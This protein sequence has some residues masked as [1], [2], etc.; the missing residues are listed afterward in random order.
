MGQ[1]VGRAVR[2]TDWAFPIVPPSYDASHRL[3]VQMPTDSDGVTVPAL[4]LAPAMRGR[5]RSKLHTIVAHCVIYFHPNAC[6]AGDSL[7]DMEVMRDGALGG[8]AAVLAPEYPGYGLMQEHEASPAG[9]DSVAAVAWSYATKYLGFPPERVLLWGRSIGTGPAASLAHALATAP[10]APRRPLAAIVLVAPFISLSAVVLAHSNSL[11]ASLVEET[12]DVASFVADPRLA[13]VP[14]VVVHPK[15]DRMVPLSQGKA[16]LGG[17]SSRIKLGVW[18]ESGTHNFI[19][20]ESHLFTVGQFFTDNLLS[21]PHVVMRR[22]VA[23]PWN[24]ST[25]TVDDLVNELMQWATTW[26][27]GLPRE[28]V[29]NR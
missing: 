28:K 19:L 25:I 14:L 18:L 1:S 10:E 23:T 13:S 9:V 7:S 17:A 24:Q 4:L 2:A 11:V 22:C 27:D 12:W 29:E 6:D 8:D 15:D 20:Q 26:Q 3:L 5:T 21:D 16:V